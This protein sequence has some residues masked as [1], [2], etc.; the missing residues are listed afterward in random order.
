[1]V[2]LTHIGQ[3]IQQPGRQILPKRFIA[4]TKNSCLDKLSNSCRAHLTSV[5]VRWERQ[6]AT[7]LKG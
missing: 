4:S 1:M 3:L 6:M 5:F 7:T 2:R